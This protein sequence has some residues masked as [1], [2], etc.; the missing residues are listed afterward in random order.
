VQLWVW[1]SEP[2]RSDLLTIARAD[3]RV[4]RLMTT[5]GVGEAAT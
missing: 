1:N 4:R 5:P 3:K 2:L